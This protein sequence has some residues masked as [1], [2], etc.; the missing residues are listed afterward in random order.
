MGRVTRVSSKGLTACRAK[1][2]SLRFS[3]M[4]PLLGTTSTY[5][6]E[7]T[8]WRMKRRRSGE[9]GDRS[10]WNDD[11]DMISNIPRQAEGPPHVTT[12]FTSDCSAKDMTYACDWPAA[13]K[14]Q[15]RFRFQRLEPPGCR[16]AEPKLHRCGF[17][18]P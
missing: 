17:S 8:R 12:E 3:T 9:R 2:F 18:T 6:S 11:V 5:A 16:E 13:E 7:R 4:A 14:P 10:E 1:P 15:T